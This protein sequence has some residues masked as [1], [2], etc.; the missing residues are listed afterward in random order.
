MT[1]IDWLDNVSRWKR[2]FISLT[3]LVVWICFITLIDAVVSSGTYTVGFL[4]FIVI[5][6]WCLYW[7]FK[8]KPKVKP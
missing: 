2:F 3:L 8:P 7:I 6:L 1:F 5:S 4:G